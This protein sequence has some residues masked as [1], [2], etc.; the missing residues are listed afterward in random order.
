M[1]P[2]SILC[3]C[4]AGLQIP[5]IVKSKNMVNLKLKSYY[6]KYYE[7]VNS[8]YKIMRYI[9]FKTLKHGVG[10]KLLLKLVSN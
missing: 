9:S 4:N 2:H 3:C 5:V 10:V 1:H 6:I 7:N 8:K